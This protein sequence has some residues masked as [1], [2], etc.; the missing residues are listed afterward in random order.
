MNKRYL[1]IVF[2]ALAM[3]GTVSAQAN[4]EF[5]KLDFTLKESEAG[6]IV[7]SRNYQMMVKTDENS[8]GTS[9]I[10]SGG[11]VPLNNGY[12][13]VGVNIDVRRVTHISKDELSLDVT[14]E[15]SGAVEP[16]ESQIRTSSPPIIRQ[17][18][19]NSTVLVPLRKAL[20]IF[21]SDD[22]TSKR[23]LQLEVTATPIH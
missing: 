12:V 10:R 8:N 20:V 17:A 18:R 4:P 13:D 7:N 11:K 16:G 1:A 15:V 2:A 9:A 23:V 5:F 3:A 6:K 14:A 19:W 21:S 22:A